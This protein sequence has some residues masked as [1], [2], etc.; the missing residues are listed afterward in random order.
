MVG[1]LAGLYV[2]NVS[3]IAPRIMVGGD[4]ACLNRDGNPER[5]RA[6]L[7]AGLRSTVLWRQ[8]GGRRL[9]LILGRSR[10]LAA[11]HRLLAEAEAE[12]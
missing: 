4:P 6:L 8:L 3:G 7:L 11:S 1:A 5:I 10:L 2:A 9:R 12:G